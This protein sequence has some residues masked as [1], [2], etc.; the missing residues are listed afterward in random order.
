M[1]KKRKKSVDK[2]GETEAKVAPPWANAHP[3]VKVNFSTQFSEE[4][5]MQMVY[6][7]ENIPKL[8]KQE[9]VRQATMLYVAQRIRSLGNS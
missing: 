2:S 9:I 4:L 5:D 3:R 7:T 8:S 1:S 6:L